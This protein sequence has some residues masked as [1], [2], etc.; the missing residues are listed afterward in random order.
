MSSCGRINGRIQSYLL[1]ENSSLDRRRWG[2]RSNCIFL[3]VQVHECKA[4]PVNAINYRGEGTGI[5]APLILNR[6]TT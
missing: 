2:R 6:G 3:N 1:L 5:M 4:V